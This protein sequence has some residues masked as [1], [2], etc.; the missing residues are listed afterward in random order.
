M[1]PLQLVPRQAGGAFGDSDM[2]SPA[3][4]RRRLEGV[5]QGFEGGT[6]AVVSLSG[7]WSSYQEFIRA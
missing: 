3:S 1:R 2:E 4:K 6:A 5:R 7:V